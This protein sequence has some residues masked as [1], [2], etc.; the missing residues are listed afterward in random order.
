MVTAAG[1]VLGSLRLIKLIRLNPNDDLSVIRLRHEAEDV[2]SILS[3]ENGNWI[4]NFTRITVESVHLPRLILPTIS[5]PVTVVHHLWMH[6][7]IYGQATWINLQ[8]RKRISL[9]LRRN[10]KNSIR[11]FPKICYFDIELLFVEIII[12]R[13]TPRNHHHVCCTLDIVTPDPFR[14]GK[15]SWKN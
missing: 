5:Q 1:I 6:V 8:I 9:L 4:Y 7:F 10:S 3:S 2:N 15:C 12:E 14:S 11:L 13:Y